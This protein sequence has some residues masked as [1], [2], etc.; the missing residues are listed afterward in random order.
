MFECKHCGHEWDENYPD[1]VP[2]MPDEAKGDICPSCNSFQ[3]KT[4][5]E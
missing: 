2:R 5:D 4:Y 1:G 3:R